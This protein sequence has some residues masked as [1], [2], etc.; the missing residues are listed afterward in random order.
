MPIA[1]KSA[2][3]SNHKFMPAM[4]YIIK[5]VANGKLNKKTCTMAHN[6]YEI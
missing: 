1:S 5:M 6:S 3:T 4:L 2:K